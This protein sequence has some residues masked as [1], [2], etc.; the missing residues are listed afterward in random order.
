MCAYGMSIQKS[1]KYETE[2][3]GH[4]HFHRVHRSKKGK[5]HKGKQHQLKLDYKRKLEQL[6]LKELDEDLPL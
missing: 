6:K 3:V 1:L 5:R 4:G 2:R